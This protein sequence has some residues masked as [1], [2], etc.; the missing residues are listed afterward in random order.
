MPAYNVAAYLAAAVE[1]VAAQTWTDWE[2]IIVDDGSTDET[3]KVA[4]R[5]AGSD[6]R[7]RVQHQRNGGISAARNRA[8]LEA[9]GEF[10]AILD[11]DD[12]WAPEYLSAQLRVFDEHPHVDVVTGNG[13]F[14]GGRHD[15]EIARPYPDI[16]PQ[17]T[18]A[19]ILGDETSIFIMSVFRRRVYERIG[20][21]DEALR[22]NEDYDYWLRAALAGFQFHRND[23]PL[24]YYRRRDDSISAVD[25]RMLAGILRVYAKLRPQLVDLPAELKILDRQ[26]ARFQRECL[27]AQARIA[28]TSG[29]TTTAADHLAALYALGGGGA[30]RVASFMARRA[31]WLLT[32]AYQLRRAYQGAAS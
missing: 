8:L 23:T 12:L 6:T 15:G 11:S 4:E 16:R 9:R 3:G 25:V 7:V 10:I 21:F 2:V 28:L 29:D 13:W 30:A 24:C 27:A 18:L 14:L 5:L 31:P 20:G 17:P 32:R 22:T 1:S 19:T 26:T